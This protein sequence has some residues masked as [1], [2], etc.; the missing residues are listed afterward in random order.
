MVSSGLSVAVFFL[1]FLEWW[2]SQ[3]EATRNI[4]NLPI[5]PPPP[6]L[7]SVNLPSAATV[8]PL[9]SRVRTNDTVLSVSGFVFCYPCIYRYVEKH[10]RCPLTKYPA[11]ADRLVK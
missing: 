11:T 4:T 8:C 6:K 10:R 9:C 2:Y 7:Q 1:Q 3:E 5:P